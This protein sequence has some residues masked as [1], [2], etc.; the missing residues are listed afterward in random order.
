M[1]QH[2]VEQIRNFN[3]LAIWTEFKFRP[4]PLECCSLTDLHAYDLWDTK[5]SFFFLRCIFLMLMMV[6]IWIQKSWMTIMISTLVKG[7]STILLC[8]SVEYYIRRIFIFNLTEGKWPRAPYYM[9]LKSGFL[10]YS[11]KLRTF[12]LFKIRK[13]GY[14]RREND[15]KTPAVWLGKK[16]LLPILHL[17]AGSPFFYLKKKGK[18][19]I[20]KGN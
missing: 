15:Q 14:Y 8:F 4:K 17:K 19:E 5:K 18:K 7:R 13:C 9:W 11:W 1:D 6:M 2:P 10:I 16:I 3:M 20:K 12:L